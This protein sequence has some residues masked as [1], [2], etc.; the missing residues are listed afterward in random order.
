ME[1]DVSWPLVPVLS[2]IIQSRTS[3]LIAR[4]ALTKLRK[5]TVRFVMSFCPH[6]TTPFLLDGFLYNSIMDCFTNIY[7]ENM[8]FIEI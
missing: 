1:C 5:A 3:D 7:S 2:L 4:D 8:I 6:G